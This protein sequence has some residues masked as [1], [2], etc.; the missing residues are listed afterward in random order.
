MERRTFISRTSGR[1][2]TAARPAT[3]IT[4][5]CGALLRSSDPADGPAACA[6]ATRCRCHQS[7]SR[8]EV[9]PFTDKQIELLETFADQAVIA[10]EN[11]RLFNET[12]RGARSSRPPRRDPAGDRELAD[13]RPAGV[14]RHR[15]ERGAAV[16]GAIRSRLQL[17]RRARASRG[18][19]QLRPRRGWTAYA[20]QYPMRPTPHSHLGPGDPERLGRP[21]SGR[22]SDPDYG[23]PHAARSRLPKPAGGA[24]APRGRADRG[25]RHLPAARPGRSP[26]SRSRCSRPSPTRR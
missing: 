1:I 6:R 16:R 9:R 25:D 17:R 18:A 22:R 23:S 19:P 11:V 3:R 15:R 4:P 21:H 10:I 5:A 8:Q 12:Q 2:R 26:T 20:R 14:R 13:R 7:G 24:D